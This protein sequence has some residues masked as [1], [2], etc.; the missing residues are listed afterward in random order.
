VF[1]FDDVTCMNLINTLDQSLRRVF[2][3]SRQNL[4]R[5]TQNKNMITKGWQQRFIQFTSKSCVSTDIG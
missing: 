3:N 5:K 4:K 1:I 2:L